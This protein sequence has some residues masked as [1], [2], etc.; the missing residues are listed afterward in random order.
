MDTIANYNRSQQVRHSTSSRQ[1]QG[2]KTG[3]ANA[4]RYHSKRNRRL[5]HMRV[6][7][8]SLVGG[9]ERA[10]DRNQPSGI[11]PELEPLK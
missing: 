9:S 2:D 11:I 5:L 6:H 10:E 7:T 3:T 1:K 8:R 4:R